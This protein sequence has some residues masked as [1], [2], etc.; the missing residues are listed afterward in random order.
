MLGAS[1]NMAQSRRNDEDFGSAK[2]ARG[3]RTRLF[4]KSF[5]GRPSLVSSPK[6]QK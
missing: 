5:E 3:T 6:R 4:R 1:L 2:Q